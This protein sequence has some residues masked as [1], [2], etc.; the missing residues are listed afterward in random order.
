M[1]SRSEGWSPRKNE[2]VR[3]CTVRGGKK[4]R[5]QRA[6]IKVPKFA[7]RA[8]IDLSSSHI[9]G[10]VSLP[11]GYVLMYMGPSNIDVEPEFPHSP[12]NLASNLSTPKIVASLVQ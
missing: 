5:Q 9:H 8:V 7:S 6:Q 11:E 4:A 3:G 10:Q 12:I 2:E 1:V